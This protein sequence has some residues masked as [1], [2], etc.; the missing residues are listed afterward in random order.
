[1]KIMSTYDRENNNPS[2]RQLNPRTREG[3][4]HKTH[5]QMS[6]C[7][8]RHGCGWLWMG[9]RNRCLSYSAKP[10]E[11]HASCSCRQRNDKLLRD[12]LYKTLTTKNAPT[13]H[14][15]VSPALLTVVHKSTPSSHSKMIPTLRQS[16][17]ESRGRWSNERD[18]CG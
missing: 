7:T 17:S 5:L 12:R 14:L 8:P 9:V 6:S 13:V 18:G 15:F 10:S 16:F 2:R 4:Y 3:R 1:M 11:R